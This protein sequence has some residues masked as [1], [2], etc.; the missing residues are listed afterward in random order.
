MRR[1]TRKRRSII[2]KAKNITNDN[3]GHNINIYNNFYQRCGYKV[4]WC[5]N[6]TQ[7]VVVERPRRNK[8][9]HIFN[10]CSL[11]CLTK[12]QPSYHLS[13]DPS[14]QPLSS[15]VIE[16][17]HPLVRRSP[18]LTSDFP[19]SSC[20]SMRTRLLRRRLMNKS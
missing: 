14:R 16:Q 3:L 11:K 6:H 19:T 18:S 20:K 2:K 5:C 1:D 9:I 12:S 8:I 4:E 15:I 7:L 13:R 17:Y 10:F